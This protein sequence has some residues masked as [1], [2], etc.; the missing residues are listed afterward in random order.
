MTDCLVVS[1][2]KVIQLDPGLS[3]LNWYS[4]RHD[5]AIQCSSL[6]ACAAHIEGCTGDT[7]LW[8]VQQLF[9]HK[10]LS[11]KTDDILAMQQPMLYT[12]TGWLCYNTNTSI[13]PTFYNSHHRGII[14]NN[15]ALPFDA[16][17]LF[18]LVSYSFN[19]NWIYYLCVSLLQKQSNTLQQRYSYIILLVT[20]IGKT[21]YL[22]A[23]INQS[24]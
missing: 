23:L 7:H 13:D 4:K 9:E 19:K 11:V 22:L 14:Q 5:A 12:F 1:V 15:D 6:R 18:V 3:L 24:L 20:A 8:C 17:S 10:R 21:G 16:L 2:L